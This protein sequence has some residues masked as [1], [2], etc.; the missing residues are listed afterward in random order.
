MTVVAKASCK[1]LEFDAVFI[2][3][4]QEVAVDPSSIDEFRMEMYVMTSRA[5]SRLFLLLTNQDDSDLQIL[6]YLPQKEKNLMEHIN[7]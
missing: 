1:G 2:P 4:L 5:R 3:D 6:D 7:E